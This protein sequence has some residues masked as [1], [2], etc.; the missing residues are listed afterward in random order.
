M[1]S[2]WVGFEVFGLFIRLEQAEGLSTG[3]GTHERNTNDFL[4]PTS[5]LGQPLSV[6]QKLRLASERKSLYSQQ[7]ESSEKAQEADESRL[8]RKRPDGHPYRMRGCLH[9]SPSVLQIAMSGLAVLD[10]FRSWDRSSR[11][12]EGHFV[13]SFRPA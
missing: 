2:K 8:V 9:A 1:V 13:Q 4:L 11:A 6:L 3:T 12:F 10:I 5:I 7:P